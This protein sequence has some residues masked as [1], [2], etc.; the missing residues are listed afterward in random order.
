MRR[1]A[2]TVLVSLVLV[3]SALAQID[4]KFDKFKNITTFMADE[5][6]ASKVTYDGGKDISILVHKMGIV[7]GFSCEG[8]VDSCKPKNVELLF[9]ARTSEWHM[10][11]NLSVNLL[12]DGKPA[13]A[14]K[15]NWDGQV[16]EAESL[17]EYNDTNISP[18]LL[19]QLAGAKSV[20]V[21]IGAFEFSMTS[22]NLAA[23]R[24]LWAHCGA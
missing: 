4:V 3:G 11:G 10:N 17:V 6:Q 18:E 20:E 5:T 8:K 19:A 16:L 12:I 15:A 23:L 1:I 7:A 9:V 24:S 13:T 21:Q 2:A 22:E 14:G